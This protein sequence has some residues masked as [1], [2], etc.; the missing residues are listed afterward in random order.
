MVCS[1]RLYAGVFVLGLE[2]DRISAL[3]RFQG[4]DLL[5]RFGLPAVLV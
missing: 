2:G 3:T 1:L 5:E 4:G